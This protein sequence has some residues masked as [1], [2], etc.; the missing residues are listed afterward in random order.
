MFCLLNKII[1]Q[2]L[3]K[4]K[5]CHLAPQGCSFVNGCL[6]AWLFGGAG[7]WEGFWMMTFMDTPGRKVST[8]AVL[9]FPLAVNMVI[10]K[11]QHITLLAECRDE[12]L[13]ASQGIFSCAVRALMEKF[14][15]E[16]HRIEAPGSWVCEFVLLNTIILLSSFTWGFYIS[17]QPPA[18]S[19][20]QLYLI[21][22]I[23]RN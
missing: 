17:P 16:I 2:K 5:K 23:K 20:I 12:L 18:P 8:S 19:I 15:W 22:G 3:Q 21:H 14:L 10:S 9:N 1:S 11:R 13:E 7:C 4:K 6:A